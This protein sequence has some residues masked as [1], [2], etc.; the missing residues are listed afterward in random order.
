MQDKVAIALDWNVRKALCRI[1]GRTFNVA[2]LTH[3]ERL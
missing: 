3:Y 1:A 2:L